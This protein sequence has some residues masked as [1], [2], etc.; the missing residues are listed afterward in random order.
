MSQQG[1]GSPRLI[2]RM[3][4]RKAKRIYISRASKLELLT[5]KLLSGSG[6]YRYRKDEIFKRIKISTFVTLVMQ[7]YSMKE[8]DGGIEIDDD[9]DYDGNLTSP[10]Q[11]GI[12]IR[13]LCHL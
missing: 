10:S 7:V 4:K 1:Q 12:N 11:A 9:D 6:D 2:I 3:N 5:E 8:M 13:V